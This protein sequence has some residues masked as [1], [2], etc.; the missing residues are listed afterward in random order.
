MLKND[1]ASYGSVAKF[2]H[3]LIFLLVTGMLLVG[4]FMQDLP[5]EY[6]PLVYNAHKVT[7]VVILFLMLSRLLWALWNVK[8]VAAMLARWQRVAERVVHAGLY[9]A[10]IAMPMTGWL[11]SSSAGKAPH[12]GDWKW[13]LP[14]VN[15]SSFIGS[16]F[17]FHEWLAYG[18]LSLLV[19]HIMAALYHHYVLKDGILKRML[20]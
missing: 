11:G 10:L 7:G 17:D 9:V 18:I 4:F 16:M 8:P 20:P 1:Q 3:W 14:I 5:R 12:I 13:Q 2:L 15:D 19:V 6:K